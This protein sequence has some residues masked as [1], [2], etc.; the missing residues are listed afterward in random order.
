MMFIAINGIKIRKPS[1]N[2]PPSQNLNESAE[3]GRLLR[4][5]KRTFIFLEGFLGLVSKN[6]LG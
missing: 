4:V 1:F 6:G 5:I 3:M 2:T